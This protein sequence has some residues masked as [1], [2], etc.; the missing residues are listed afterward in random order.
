ML[1]VLR[2]AKGHAGGGQQVA[3]SHEGVWRV[4]HEMFFKIQ[5]VQSCILV[6]SRLIM[7]GP[8]KMV[9]C[10]SKHR[11]SIG[12]IIHVNSVKEVR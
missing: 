1:A 5:S 10:I 6:L 4:R 7:C 2:T 3:S 12:E 9:N 8:A 11:H